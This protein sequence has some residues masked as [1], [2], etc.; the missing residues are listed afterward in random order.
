MSSYSGDN[1]NKNYTGIPEREQDRLE[2]LNFSPSTLETVDYAIY[3]FINDELSLK[4]NTNKGVEKVPVIWASA[5]RSFQ[6]KN[7]KEY[8]DSEGLIILPAITI[9]R[10]S[11]V[12]ELTTRG[13]YY[14]GMFP[15]QTQPEKGGSIVISRRIKQDKTSN[16]AN[17]D[18]NRRYN[19]R[20]APKFVR[21]STS[22]VVY[23]TVSIPPIVYADINYR[24]VL[25]TEYQQQMN[26]LLQ[27]F[28]TRPGTINSFLIHRD[29]HRY[30]A[31][32][33]GNFAL[34]NNISAMENEERRF[35]TEVDI[36]VM[37]YLVG[38]GINQKT[39]KF[40]IR[41]NAVQVRIPREHVVWDDPLVVGGADND[42]SQNVGVDG[43][44]RE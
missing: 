18:T 29:G 13:A 21:K 4:T 19:N 24:I 38:E 44:Y 42:N 14:G 35:Q 2:D 11:V 40:S 17:A 34:N 30:E 3:D 27:P 5:E 12:N 33:Q 41:E 31:F 9:E 22:K 28:I 1:Q 15:F 20:T 43:K 23:E 8:R 25:R 26:D 10:T 37:G 16:F 39:P 6:V 36:R 32:V 7:N